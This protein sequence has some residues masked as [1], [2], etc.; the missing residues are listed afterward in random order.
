MLRIFEAAEIDKRFVAGKMGQTNRQRFYKL[1]EQKH[2][3]AVFTPVEN[4]ELDSHNC[5]VLSAWVYRRIFNR[6]ENLLNNYFL[7]ERHAAIGLSS[8]QIITN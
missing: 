7:S 2:K 8:L 3:Q 6:F 5:P 1:T 4:K